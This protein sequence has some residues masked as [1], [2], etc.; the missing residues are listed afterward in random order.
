MAATGVKGEAAMANPFTVRN[1]RPRDL[2]DHK[3]PS[4]DRTRSRKVEECR[5]SERERGAE[6]E[7]SPSTVYDPVAF[8]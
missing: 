3:T 5:R 4:I 2:V 1:T 7:H 8:I 6:E